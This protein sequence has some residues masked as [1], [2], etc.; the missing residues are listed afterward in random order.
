MILGIQILIGSPQISVYT[1]V[2]ISIY[3]FFNLIEGKNYELKYLIILIIPLI[4]GGLISSVQLIPSLETGDYSVR[5]G[6][7]SFEYSNIYSMEY[8]DY[9]TIFF[10]KFFGDREHFYWWKGGS[11]NAMSPYVGIM[12]LFLAAISVFLTKRN[13]SINFFFILAILGIILTFGN[14]IISFL[15]WKLPVF[16]VLRVKSRYLFLFNFSS[17]ILAGWGLNKISNKSFSK[18]EKKK[19]H[20][21]FKIISIIIILYISTSAFIIGFK[22]YKQL[23]LPNVN[24]DLNQK[25]NNIPSFSY[26]NQK[27]NILG[28]ISYSLTDIF[29]FLVFYSI[30]AFIIKLKINK[31][32]NY[33]SLIVILFIIFNLWFYNINSVKVKDYDDVLMQNNYTKFLQKNLNLYRYHE[34]YAGEYDYRNDNI[35]LKNYKIRGSNPIK[36]SYYNKLLNDINLLFNNTEHPLINLI[37]VKFIVSDYELNNS[38]LKFLYY[39]NPYYLYENKEVFPRSFIISNDS[40]CNLTIKN[41]SFVEK[42]D[43]S[44][45]CIYN[46]STIDYYSENEII[47][48]TN[49]SHKGFLILTD[50]FYPGWKAY[51]DGERTKI[52]RGF[53]VFRSIRIN[54]GYHKIRFVFE[55]ESFK[56]GAFLSLTTTSFCFFIILIKLFNSEEN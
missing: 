35:L 48:K 37:G 28:V 42:E 54:E 47:I 41:Y 7:V 13:K 15:F 51:V 43:I 19:Y 39:S 1:F 44:N 18:K 30:S 11:Y 2:G 34:V 23:F 20:K 9:V 8:E 55:P 36:I 4:I 46:E 38:G 24:I 5:G 45:Y 31:K 21:F 14:T 27:I 22:L 6:G 40:E 16:N 29:Y 3:W 53:K 10:P 33:F 17:A 12:T 25:Q 49:S 32:I 50:V 26:N 52:Y 56:K